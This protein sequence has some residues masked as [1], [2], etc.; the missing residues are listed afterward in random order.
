MLRLAQIAALRIT[1]VVA[2]SLAP[3]SAR[4][5]QPGGSPTTV[6]EPQQ[7]PVVPLPAGTAAPFDGLLVPPLTF[8]GY[9]RL[10]AEAGQLRVNLKE[11]DDRLRVCVPEAAGCQVALQQCQSKLEPKHVLDRFWV[12]VTVATIVLG[13]LAWGVCKAAGNC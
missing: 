9:L 13:G 7:P 5:Q 4:A 11:R 8:S 2:V 3:L 10:Q 1:L 6:E 12:G